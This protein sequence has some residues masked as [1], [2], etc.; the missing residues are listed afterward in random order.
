V[1]MRLRMSNLFIGEV[2]QKMSAVDRVGEF[3]VDAGE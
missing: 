2:S 1:V 3:W